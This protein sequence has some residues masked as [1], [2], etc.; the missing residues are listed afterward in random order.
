M[1]LATH[2]K[3]P[4]LNVIITSPKNQARLKDIE[5]ARARGESDTPVVVYLGLA[6][7]AMNR[8]AHAAPGS[9]LALSELNR[10]QRHRDVRA[11]GGGD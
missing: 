7:T 10:R 11:H 5:A 4:I 3:R 2:E 9:G 6:F 8:V 1:L